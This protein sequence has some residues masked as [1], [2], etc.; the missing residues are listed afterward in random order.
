MTE[1]KIPGIDWPAFVKYAG[2]DELALVTDPAGWQREFAQ[3][4]FDPGDFLVDS[5]GR[6]FTLPLEAQPLS[7]AASVEPDE[8]DRL[9]RG[10]FAALGECCIAKLPSLP[11][12]EVMRL[13]QDVA[14]R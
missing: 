6:R 1:H 2:D 14:D 12:R 3:F 7:Q 4:A 9:L 8:L 5:G 11:A 10:H 13:L